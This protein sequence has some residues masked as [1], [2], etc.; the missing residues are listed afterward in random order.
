LITYLQVPIATA[1][2]GFN[3]SEIRKLENAYCDT[4]ANKNTEKN[5][6]TY[7]Y[8]IN[9]CQYIIMNQGL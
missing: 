3:I 9:K 4:R 2:N 6:R 1:K 7:L 5:A 8:C